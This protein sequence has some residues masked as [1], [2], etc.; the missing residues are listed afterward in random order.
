MFL[1][2]CRSYLPSPQSLLSALPQQ[3]SPPLQIMLRVSSCSWDTITARDTSPTSGS[4]KYVSWNKWQALS[5][6]KGDY[7]LR[8]ILDPYKTS[9]KKVEEL[10]PPLKFSTLYVLFKN[11]YYVFT[12]RVRLTLA[13]WHVLSS[14]WN[15][16]AL[17]WDEPWESCHRHL[18][19]QSRTDRLLVLDIR[20]WLQLA[21][22]INISP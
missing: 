21:E 7:C 17:Q 11:I 10:R 12:L 8:L 19:A 4:S 13:S 22:N 14:F 9:N 20:A 6:K 16:K 3:L 18:D 1:D 15:L 5:Q 2:I